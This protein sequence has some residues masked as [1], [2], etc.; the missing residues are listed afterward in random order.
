M[1]RRPLW[2]GRFLA[3]GFSLIEMLVVLVIMGLLA[4]VAVLTGAG[5]SHA[6]LVSS[7]REVAGLL[8]EVRARAGNA[9]RPQRVVADVE[10]NRLWAA[11]RAETSARVVAVPRALRISL[12][13]IGAEA[14]S[15]ARGAILFFPDGSSTGGGV[16]LERAGRQGEAI[17]VSVD[18]LTGRVAIEDGETRRSGTGKAR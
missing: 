16:R 5:R 2:R 1:R 14:L 8:R 7:A 3:A 15:S 17:I 11:D 12:I 13:T 9:N 10:L 4:G 6:E 18:W